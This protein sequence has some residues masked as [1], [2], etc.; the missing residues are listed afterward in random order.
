[1]LHPIFTTSSNL[2]GS[3]SDRGGKDVKC[4]ICGSPLHEVGYPDELGYQTYRCENDCAFW[5]T[6]SWKIRKVV[7]DIAGLIVIGGMVMLTAPLWLPVVVS[8]Q[9]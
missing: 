6:W 7:G 1:M 9:D 2:Q 3:E 5:E 4:V 8:G